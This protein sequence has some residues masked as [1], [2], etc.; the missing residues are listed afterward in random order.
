LQPCRD[1]RFGNVFAALLAVL[2]LSVVV[3]GCGSTRSTSHTLVA[4]DIDRSTGPTSKRGFDI[5]VVG[6]DG[7][8][9]RP[10]TRTRD[11]MGPSWSPGGKRIAFSCGN[12]HPNGRGGFDI[13]VM[14]A[15]GSSLRRL[16]RV[17]ATGGTFDQPA[18]SP[19]GKAIAAVCSFDICLVTSKGQVQQLTQTMSEPLF[20]GP[21]WSPDGRSMASTC[22][23]LGSKRFPTCLVDATDGSVRT[24]T[25]AGRLEGWTPVGKLV[26]SSSAGPTN[27]IALR[28]LRSTAIIGLQRWRVSSRIH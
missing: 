15:D 16:T 13:C 22:L 5:Y 18:W 24:V 17:A 21:I 2:L 3:V 20:L 25:R 27:A 12:G 26:I 9:L 10:L 11:N 4:F 1:G 19:D 6:A 14:N 23:S 28:Q 7:S 8:G